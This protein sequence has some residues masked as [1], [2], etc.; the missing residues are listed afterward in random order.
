MLFRSMLEVASQEIEN[1]KTTIDISDVWLDGYTGFTFGEYK[2]LEAIA[3]KGINIHF[4]IT[5]DGKDSIYAEQ[6][7]TMRSEERSVG[8]EC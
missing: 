2:I 3:K 6:N 4:N 8:K 7:K 1:K 5:T